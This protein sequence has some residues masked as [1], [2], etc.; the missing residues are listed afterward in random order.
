MSRPLNCWAKEVSACG[1]EAREKEHFNRALPAV[2]VTVQEASPPPA[3][4]HDEHMDDP[5]A[6]TLCSKHAAE[7]AAIDAALIDLVNCIREIE[8]LRAVRSKVA[9]N[10][11]VHRFVVDGVGVERSILKMVMDHAVVQRR[12]LGGWQPPEWLPKAVFGAEELKSG[13]GLAV[14]VRLGDTVVDR[15]RIGFT[16]TRSAPTNVCESVVLELRQG[17]RL[18][19]TWQTPVQSLGELRSQGAR[20]DAAS[21]TLWH[22]RRVSFSNGALDLGLSL[23]FDWSGKWAGGKHPAVLALRGKFGAA[24]Q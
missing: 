22:P 17:L 5:H 23:D 20:Y 2:H 6:G 12:A 14:V 3:D 24:P 10:W 18:V 11:P 19:C 7:L 8:R 16:F 1:E 21:D 13:C 4:A 15:E 9:K